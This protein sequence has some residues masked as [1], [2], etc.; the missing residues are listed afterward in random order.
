MEIT[1]RVHGGRTDQ[2]AVDAICPGMVG[3]REMRAAIALPREQSCA[4]VLAGVRESVQLAGCVTRDD[5]RLARDFDGEIVAGVCDFIG[6]SGE[7]PGA[8]EYPVDLASIE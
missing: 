8:Q 6:T 1:R 2:A 7:Y 3:T 5:Q 4:A